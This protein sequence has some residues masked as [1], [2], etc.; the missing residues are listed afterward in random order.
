MIFSV[1]LNATKIIK[2]QNRP[3]MFYNMLTFHLITVN[4]DNFVKQQQ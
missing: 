4:T 3:D 2:N 1:C